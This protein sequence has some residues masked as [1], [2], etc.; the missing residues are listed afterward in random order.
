MRPEAKAMPAAISSQDISM[1]RRERWDY[2]DPFLRLRLVPT[3][4]TEL[5]A[6][7]EVLRLMGKHFSPSDKEG[8]SRLLKAEAII[9]TE[10]MIEDMAQRE[11]DPEAGSAMGDG[12]ECATVRIDHLGLIMIFIAGVGIIWMDEGGSEGT[13]ELQVVIDAVGD[14]GEEATQMRRMYMRAVLQRVHPTSKQK[15]HGDMAS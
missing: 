7:L 5:A 13:D 12:V 15:L 2:A 11:Y 8:I 3:I 4:Y 1:L 10:K 14:G 6:R 9:P